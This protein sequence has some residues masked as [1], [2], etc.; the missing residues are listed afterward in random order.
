MKKFWQSLVLI[1]VV[2]AAYAGDPYSEILWYDS[3]AG[4]TFTNAIPIGNGYMGGM[5]YGGVE[6]DV[7]NLN[8]GTVRSEE[9]R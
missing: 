7:I 4:N 5:I 8:E 1:F 9:R 3:D 6:K 2:S